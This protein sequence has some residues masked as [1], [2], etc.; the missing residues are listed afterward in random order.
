MDDAEADVLA[1]MAFP[2]QH[3]TKLHN[4]NPL[5]RL[6]TEVKCRADVAGIFPNEDNIVR[7]IAAVLPE[8]S[9]ERQL[10]H[11][12]MQVEAVA[13][14]KHQQSRRKRRFR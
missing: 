10:Q 12:Y 3:R 5:E 7:L 11:R 2:S 9:D 13:D 14:L 6:S 4:T 1:C 8:A